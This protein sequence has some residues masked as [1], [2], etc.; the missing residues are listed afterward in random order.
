MPLNNP[1][2]NRARPL[3]LLRFVVA[4]PNSREDGLVHHVA[5]AVGVPEPEEMTH[6]M[7]QD[8]QQ[9]NHPCRRPVGS[10][11]GIVRRGRVDEPAV[12]G[13]VAVDPDAPPDANPS[14]V[15]ARSATITGTPRRVDC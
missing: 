5:I 3:S 11:L 14:C 2:T 4:P 1:G 12:P 10:E 15:P 8:G 9:V 6:L 13:G 7:N